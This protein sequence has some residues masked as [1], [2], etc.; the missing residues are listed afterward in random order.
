MLKPVWIEVPVKDINRA[1]KFYQSVFQLEAGEVA[2]DGVRETITLVNTS[3]GGAPGISLN[4][5][6]NFEPS[7]KGMFLYLDVGD[8]MP[9]ALTRVTA[10]GGTVVTPKTSMGAAGSY[11]AVKDTEGNLFG[12]YC[13][14]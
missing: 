6:A 1:A 12:L 3:E 9:N 7:D 10:A 11:A 2:N 13:Y 8:D 4:K 5:T 14:P